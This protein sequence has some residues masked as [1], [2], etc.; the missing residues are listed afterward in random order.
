MGTPPSGKVGAA[1]GWA[2]TV[3]QGGAH[4]DHR[5]ALGAMKWV[6]GKR[7]QKR[8]NKPFYLLDGPGGPS[9]PTAVS[10]LVTNNCRGGGP[11]RA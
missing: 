11:S 10:S 4:R 6:F 9:E 2:G 7:P 3:L 5:W 8:K 1:A